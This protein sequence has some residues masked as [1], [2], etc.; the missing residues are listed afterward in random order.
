MVIFFIKVHGFFI[1]YNAVFINMR[2][3]IFIFLAVNNALLWSQIF[4][5]DSL[6]YD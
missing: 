1:K 4:Y 6:D 3:C 5:L 2:V